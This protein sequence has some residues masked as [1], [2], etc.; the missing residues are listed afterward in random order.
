MVQRKE[1]FEISGRFFPSGVQKRWRKRKNTER[2]KKTGWE[3]K[4][5]WEIRRDEKGTAIRF[6]SLY[7]VQRNKWLY[8]STYMKN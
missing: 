2:E 1:K 4:A 8:R 7:S 3:K 6:Y 5:G